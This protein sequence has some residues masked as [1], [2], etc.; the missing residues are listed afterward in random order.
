VALT[1]RVKPLTQYARGKG[2]AGGMRQGKEEESRDKTPKGSTGSLSHPAP[3]RRSSADAEHGQHPTTTT[4]I[5]G[6]LLLL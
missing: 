2:A 5:K 6:Y 4:K 3:P 1:E